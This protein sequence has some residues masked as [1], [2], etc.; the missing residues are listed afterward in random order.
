MTRISNTNQIRAGAAIFVAWLLMASASW[1]ERNV[2]VPNDPTA[3]ED[4][5]RDQA[6]GNE[7]IFKRGEVKNCPLGQQKRGPREPRERFSKTEGGRLLE[8]VE[9]IAAQA[10]IALASDE[11]KAV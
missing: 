3:T 10:G 8:S 1:A 6:V 4:N 2:E 9:M 11:M 5:R 7:C